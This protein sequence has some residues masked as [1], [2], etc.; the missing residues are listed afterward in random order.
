MFSRN[1]LK[2]GF[3][4]TS[5]ILSGALAVASPLQYCQ[6]NELQHT[7][8]C[9]AI[10]TFYNETSKANDFYIL[11]SA[12]FDYR[13]GYAAFGT[14]KTMDGSLIFVIY[15]GEKDGDVTASV[16]TTTYHN[17][18]KTSDSTPKHEVI[19]TWIEDS[20]YYN[21]QIVCYSCDTWTGNAASVNSTNQGW[22]FASHYTTT[23][24][25]NDV[26]KPL[27]LHTDYAPFELDMTVSHYTDVAP[28]APELVKNGRKS[29]GVGSGEGSHSSSWTP[30]QL[31]AIHGLIL[32]FAF[33]ILMPL[34]VAGIRSGHPK[35]FKI[36]WIIQISS[37]I[38][39]TSGIAWG[40]Y[41][42]R[43]EEQVTTLRESHELIGFLV[44]LGLGWA[45]AL[46]YWHHVRYLKIG[47]ATEVT[48]W[49]RG[50]GATVLT[51]SWVNIFL[52]LYVA[53]QPTW[54]FA[55]AFLLMVIS[56][57]VIYSSSKLRA[58]IYGNTRRD[59]EYNTVA[60]EDAEQKLLDDMKQ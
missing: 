55:V 40:I 29:V 5:A 3:A 37:A 31:Y 23:M 2:F 53:N 58:L 17:P 21:A 47:R 57:V 18:P 22:I 44:L 36:H 28:I 16:R 10:S 11:L 12:K 43:G 27:T 30:R 25:S 6:F 20:S 52:G 9:L 56:S 39:A 50:L 15:P 46:G 59:I 8:Q 33:V 13:K 41:I 32:A 51:A 26:S 38:L 45:P 24:Q 14:G 35:A 4:V 54:Y 7:D 1:V 48:K 49:H 34:G 42:S 60:E 19:K